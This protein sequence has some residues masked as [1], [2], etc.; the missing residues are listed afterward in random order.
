MISN[1]EFSFLKFN[2]SNY[3]EQKTGYYGINN[4]AFAIDCWVNWTN[5]SENA[6]LFENNAAT[7]FPFTISIESYQLIFKCNNQ[8]LSAIIDERFGTWFHFCCIYDDKNGKME[9]YI[10]GKFINRNYLDSPIKNLMLVSFVI[11]KPKDSYSFKGN[12]AFLR[13]FNNIS[14]LKPEFT[15]SNFGILDSESILFQY[16]MINPTGSY[17]SGINGTLFIN[18]NIENE[19]LSQVPFYYAIKETV[20]YI[21]QQVTI[22]SKSEIKSNSNGLTIEFWLQINPN[23]NSKISLMG[24]ESKNELLSHIQFETDSDFVVSVFD[25]NLPIIQYKQDLDLNWHHYAIVYDNQQ[26]VTL[27]IDGNKIITEELISLDYPKGNLNMIPYCNNNGSFY[28]ISELRIWSKERSIDEIKDKML[29]RIDT[30]SENLLAYCAFNIL[31]FPSTNQNS[32][33]QIIG[34][35]QGISYLVANDGPFSNAHFKNA[36]YFENGANGFLHCAGWTVNYPLDFSIGFW[37]KRNSY[38]SNQTIISF[39]NFELAIN[40]RNQIILNVNGVYQEIE[41]LNKQPVWQYWTVTRNSG[42]QVFSLYIDGIVLFEK[43]LN[44]FSTFY[45]ITFGGNFNFSNQ[46]Y[47]AIQGI[48]LWNKTLDTSEISYYKNQRLV[49]TEPGLINYW[50]LDNYS[51]TKGYEDS[52]RKINIF[53]LSNNLKPT[54]FH[55]PTVI[56]GNENGGNRSSI[57]LEIQNKGNAYILDEKTKAQE[58]KKQAN[59]EA[60]KIIAAAHLVA[61]R[62]LQRKNVDFYLQT[63]QPNGRIYKIKTNGNSELITYI[64]SICGNNIPGV[65]FLNRKFYW[66]EPN[67][68]NRYV[69]FPNYERLKLYNNQSLNIINSSFTIMMAL[70]FDAWNR[71]VFLFNAG[72]NVVGQGF[73]IKVTREN[74]I[75]FGDHQMEFGNNKINDNLL[76]SNWHI[77]TVSFDINSL[78][79]QIYFDQTLVSDGYVLQRGIQS[80]SQNV[81]PGCDWNGNNPFYGQMAEVRV[82]NTVENYFLLQ[83]SFFKFEIYNTPNLR[84]IWNLAKPNN[85]NPLST[86]LD[87]NKGWWSTYYGGSNMQ[88]SNFEYPSLCENV[89]KFNG[90]NSYIDLGNRRFTNGGGCMIEFSAINDAPNRIGILMNQGS[91]GNWYFFKIYFNEQNQFVFD[92]DG[93]KVF[94]NSS[95]YSSGWNLW[96][97]FV[98]ESMRKVV[99]WVNGV[100]VGS[101]P[102]NYR[103]QYEQP[104]LFGNENYNTTTGFMGK[105]TGLRINTGFMGDSILNRT[106]N[107]NILSDYLGTDYTVNKYLFGTITGN[108]LKDLPW[109][110]QYAQMNNV[111]WISNI[112]LKNG[113]KLNSVNFDGSNF[114]QTFIPRND[115]NISFGQIGNSRQSI[116]SF[117]EATGNL[118]A[119]Y[120]NTISYLKFDTLQKV[121]KEQSNLNWVKIKT[122][123]D[124]FNFNSKLIQSINQE[125]SCVINRNNQQLY[126]SGEMYSFLKLDKNIPIYGTYCLANNTIYYTQA[127]KIYAYNQQQPV[128]IIQANGNI[129]S[130]FSIPEE[131]FIYIVYTGNNEV[132]VYDIELDNFTSY[133]NLPVAIEDVVRINAVDALVQLDQKI[134]EQMELKRLKMDEA[135]KKILLAREAAQVKY[136][137]IKTKLD[138]ETKISN[139]KIAAK[140]L[141][142]NEKLALERAKVEQK[143][144]EK[145][146]KIKEA[147]ENAK[148]LKQKAIDKGNQ[149][150]NEA[151]NEA[152]KTNASSLLKFQQANSLQ[153]QMAK[154]M[155]QPAD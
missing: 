154:G 26:K 112:L 110:P 140:K 103:M 1:R 60:N 107:Y 123:K 143:K 118:Y 63:K 37:L 139:E 129:G 10:N 91:L 31:N 52:L 68:F 80:L 105:M 149:I 106:Q 121:Q 137:Y 67:T 134:M 144:L 22:K 119:A 59:I 64:P 32:E 78:R 46:F 44:F 43:P 127:N 120:V 65:D 76:D 54:D 24:I 152:N 74:R 69:T 61:K 94:I 114:N 132:S 88:V 25:K 93:A 11:A 83:N 115:I 86:T 85:G 33:F 70:K 104:I 23:G 96:Q 100:E 8:T 79:V 34:S 102:Y 56:D 18:G 138:L 27:Y 35:N 40:N 101:A 15:V 92:W 50:D 155:I 136:G 12:I 87:P 6:M 39:D 48:S 57:L 53:M 42:S 89:L 141:Q 84:A 151:Q 128:K 148:E 95:L 3:L 81:Y 133:C 19:K 47:G 7:N 20:G 122:E 98:S 73:Y 17:I 9:I 51:F 49:G 124:L 77:I 2:G 4:S 30:K 36:C 38:N 16:E 146:N 135:A 72:E 111:E 5:R 109:L 153:E 55:K 21:N 113:Y 45:N 99:V 66:I 150:Q 62:K 90:Y 28:E 82:Y 130:I 145:I 29:L 14:L 108:K 126:F 117:D 71:E 97:C 13:L 75:V 41:A 125:F 58:L 147:K 116:N 131:K 142:T